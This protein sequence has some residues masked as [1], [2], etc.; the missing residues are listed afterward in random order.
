MISSALRI[1][2]DISRL[3]PAWLIR[4]WVDSRPKITFA[5]ACSRA[6]TSSSSV[7]PSSWSCRTTRQMVCKA[8]SSVSRLSAV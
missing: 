6:R 8:R 2:P 3:R 7:G 4:A 1:S 5:F